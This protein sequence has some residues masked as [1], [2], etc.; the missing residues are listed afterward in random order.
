M[1][2]HNLRFNNDVIT[3][4][5]MKKNHGRGSSFFTHEEWDMEIGKQREDNL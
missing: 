1:N 4:V 2:Q 5:E 3:M